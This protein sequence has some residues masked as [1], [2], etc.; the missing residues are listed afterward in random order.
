MKLY[1]QKLVA[2]ARKNASPKLVGKV[3]LYDIIIKPLFT[4][5]TMKLK[6]SQNKYF[7]VVDG[8]ASKNDVKIAIE[9]IYGVKPV[10]V[11]TVNMPLKKRFNRMVRRAYKKAIVTLKDGD[12]ISVV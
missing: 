2:R 7:F 4:E 5:K 8:R 10:N 12:K 9:Q 6:D 11:N 1:R 3:S